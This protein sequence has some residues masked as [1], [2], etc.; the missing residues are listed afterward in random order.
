MNQAETSKPKK[1][2]NRLIKLVLLIILLVFAGVIIFGFVKSKMVANYLANMPENASPVTAYKV[3]YAEWTPVINSTGL[4]RPNQGA[5]L[6][7]QSAGTVTNILIQSGQKVKKGDLLVEIDSSVEQASLK[8]AEAQL[9][10]ARFTYQRYTN[11]LKSKSVSQS[12]FDSAK[13]TYDALVAEIE[14]LKA[15]I[16]RRQI[17]APFDGQAGIVKVNVGEY[18]TAG[19]EI[20]RVEDRSS[21]KVDFSVA[22]N[23]LEKL[24]LGQ[25][26]TATADALLGETFGAKV[27]AIEPAIDSATGLITVQATFDAE[28][29]QKLLSGMFVRLRVALPTETNQI[30]LPQVAITYNM[31]GETAYILTALSDEDKQKLADNKDL[32]RMYR[33]N[34][35]TVTTKDRQGIYAQLEGK[36]VNV[37][38]LVVTGGQQRLS[39]NSLVVVSEQEGVGTQAPA[40]KTNL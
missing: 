5:M 34:Q 12:E 17:Y 33:A 2:Q 32:E 7:A 36:D 19:T 30:I 26:V 13:A 21:M 15:S 20:V 31:Y 37:G 38:D 22:Q 3:E 14:S 4:V 9:P 35:I 6:S 10:A 24:A 16:E 8:Q 25:K 39:N 1:S 28:S 29:S 40:T 27:T 23:D 18:I 11:L